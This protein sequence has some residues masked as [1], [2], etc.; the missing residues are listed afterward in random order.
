MIEFDPTL[1]ENDQSDL[2]N[3]AEQSIKSKLIENFLFSHIL[4]IYFLAIDQ[5]TLS[6]EM[7][8]FYNWLNLACELYKLK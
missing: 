4:K 3:R 1:K 6:D 2:Y 7:K 8:V 5:S